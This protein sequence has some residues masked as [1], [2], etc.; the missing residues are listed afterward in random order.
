MK[1]SF[2]KNFLGLVVV[3]AFTQIASAQLLLTASLT[4]GVNLLRS[5]ATALNEIQITD[6][7]GAANTIS[8]YDNSSASSTNTVKPAYVSYAYGRGTN[9]TTFTNLAGVIQTNNFVYLARTATTN[10]AITNVARLLYRTVVPAN[11][12]VTLIPDNAYTFG[13][14]LQI[15]ASSNAIVNASYEPLP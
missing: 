9:V 7:G 12:T 13:L 15:V 10:A 11:G 3:F 2:L 8:I 5:G 14:G 1:S 6:T 4:N